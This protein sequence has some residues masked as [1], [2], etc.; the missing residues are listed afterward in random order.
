MCFFGRP[1]HI[2]AKT[3]TA[4][5]FSLDFNISHASSLITHFSLK[6]KCL[7]FKLPQ[8]VAFGSDEYRL[9]YIM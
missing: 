4:E 6:E 8:S 3:P 5:T 9:T 1:A 7:N 2:V